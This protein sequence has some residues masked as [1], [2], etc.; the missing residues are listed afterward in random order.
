MRLSYILA[1]DTRVM[2]THRHE[3]DV[4]EARPHSD[5]SQAGYGLNE[6]VQC[7]YAIRLHTT[8]TIHFL[9]EGGN[10]NLPSDKCQ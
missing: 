4:I 3:I 7:R 10:S 9:Q 6:Q 5:Y 1:R 2:A 8:R